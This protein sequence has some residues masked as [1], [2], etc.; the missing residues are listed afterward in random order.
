MSAK[1]S[2]Q[3]RRR[4][5][6]AADAAPP[7]APPAAPPGAPPAPAD[8]APPEAPTNENENP[9]NGMVCFIP[10][11]TTA[12][13]LAVDGGEAPEDLH[14]T[15]V[16]L[17]DITAL[18]RATVEDTIS[19]TLEQFDEARDAEQAAAGEDDDDTISGVFN[20]RARFAADPDKGTPIVVTFDSPDIGALQDA[21]QAMLQENVDGMP[22]PTHGFVPHLTVQYRSDVTDSDPLEVDPPP[23]TEASF[24]EVTLVWGDI[25]DPANVSVFPLAASPDDQTAPAVAPEV[26][27][28]QAMSRG[29][30]ADAPPAPPAPAPDAPADAAP[31]GPTGGN[32]TPYQPAPYSADPDETVTCPACGL[33]DDTDAA[34]CDQCGAAL[35]PTTDYTADA[36]EIVGCPAC[37]LM[38]SGD[39]AFC[40][41]CG[42]PLT[43]RTDVAVAQAAPPEAP[44]EA[45]PEGDQELAARDPVDPVALAA[46][47]A[48]T[49]PAAPVSGDAPAGGPAPPDQRPMAAVG[50][51]GMFEIQFLTAGE[52]TDDG[53]LIPSPDVLELRAPPVP[54]T[55][56]LADTG[57]EGADLGGVGTEIVWDGNNLM[58]RG[59]Y[60]NDSDGR[61]ARFKENVDNGQL[62]WPSIAMGNDVWD[63]EIGPDG[64]EK[65]TLVSGVFLGGA[66]LPFEA[67]HTGWIRS[68]PGSE[69]TGPAEPGAPTTAPVAAAGGLVACGGPDNPPPE[70]FRDP[71]LPTAT[72]IA[73]LETGEVYGHAALWGA[74]HRSFQSACLDPPRTATGYREFL[75]GEVLCADGS[76]VPTGPLTVGTGHAGLSLN[77]AAARGH[78][79][80]SGYAVADVT[81]GEDAIGIWV[82]GAVRP[83]ATA[84]QVAALRASALSGD[85]RPV[86]DADSLELSALLAVNMPGFVVP[87][88]ARVASGAPG[89]PDHVTALITTGTET[90]PLED[91]GSVASWRMAALTAAA[92]MD[93]LIFGPA[94]AEVYRLAEMDAAVSG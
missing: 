31:P 45:P 59:P 36:D 15:L 24:T 58:V 4:G 64:S 13:A 60:S 94:D 50:P 68:I 72:P 16:F 54:I 67:Q 28:Q 38:N 12:A 7:P 53:R 84:S 35:T 23:M 44:A 5:L 6:T 2:R 18:D 10:D 78:Y 89:K 1:A 19:A 20:G 57:H 49:P 85:W 51:L 90:H 46:R 34:F 14:I 56:T 40:D 80:N 11:P 77:A 17:G 26:P 63:V 37:G 73:V 70:W 21:L 33:M 76:R 75:T 91:L 9:G 88:V 69:A 27:A 32:G 93:S 30:L 74:C 86:T 71:E 55:Y 48:E 29:K 65:L 3:P 8:A 47:L 41:Q 81:V 79:D 83:G 62:T 42:I 43:G 92:Y 25:T 66:I 82:H 61:G 39:A 52:W 22:E 87:R